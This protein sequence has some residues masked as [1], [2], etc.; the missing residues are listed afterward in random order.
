MP[1]RFEVVVTRVCQEEFFEGN[2]FTVVIKHSCK[3]LLEKSLETII[4]PSKKK[5]EQNKTTSF[6][7]VPAP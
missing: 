7:V 3:Q 5:P 6:S 2:I 1:Q 4:A